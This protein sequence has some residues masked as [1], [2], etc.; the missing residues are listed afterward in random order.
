M[1]AGVLLAVVA[2]AALLVSA[3]SSAQTQT[4]KTTWYW[5]PGLCKSELAKFG[6]QL[7]DGRVFHVA[8]AFC[9]GSGG[10]ATC[11]WSSGRRY[12]LYDRFSAFVRSNDGVVR[13]FVLH[14]TARSAGY[15]A[16]SFKALGREPNATRF[17]T[18][19]RPIATALARMEQQKGCAPYSP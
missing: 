11:E 10:T 7:T 18:L 19:V 12:R 3:P 13:T 1:K 9:V 2:A 17:N 4:G 16:D 5:T 8:N 14:P 15:R 6:M